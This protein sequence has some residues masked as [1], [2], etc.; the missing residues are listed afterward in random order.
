M[1]RALAC[2]SGRASGG[3]RPVSGILCSAQGLGRLA[4]SAFGL[5]PYSGFRPRHASGMRARGRACG[6][7]GSW[8]LQASG[9][10][11]RS[12]LPDLSAGGRGGSR[13]GFRQFGSWA[14]VNG[15]WAEGSAVPPEAVVSAALAKHASAGQGQHQRGEAVA[16]KHVLNGAGELVDPEGELGRV[17]RTHH[18]KVLGEPTLLPNCFHFGGRQRSTARGGC[19]RSTRETRERWLRRLQYL[20]PATTTLIYHAKFV[21]HHVPR[22][23]AFYARADPERKL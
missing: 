7:F 18:S 3:Q 14:G 22:S 15:R 13:K 8:R 20:H 23:F 10:W 5:G 9:S 12:C 1:A 16:C 11:P 21:F 17:A 2:C 6:G 4:S 19:I